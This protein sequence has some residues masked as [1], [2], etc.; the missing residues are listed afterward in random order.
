MHRQAR[1][2]DQAWHAHDAEKERD[3]NAEMHIAAWVSLD[4][5]SLS[6]P[7]TNQSSTHAFTNSI[8]VM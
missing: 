3:L 1:A 4:L 8:H 7:F 6:H 2:L 5:A